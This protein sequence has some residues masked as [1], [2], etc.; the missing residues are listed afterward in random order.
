MN[1]ANQ[2]GVPRDAEVQS[3]TGFKS[4]VFKMPGRSSFYFEFRYNTSF[5]LD[6][7]PWCQF[8]G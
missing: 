4:S 2:V 7:L 1:P 6:V 3:V 5:D 8:K